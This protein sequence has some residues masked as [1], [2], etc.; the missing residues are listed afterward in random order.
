MRMP[1]FSEIIVFCASIPSSGVLDCPKTSADR[2][3]AAREVVERL[4]Q[5]GLGGIISLMSQEVERYRAAEKEA[6]PSWCT[7][8]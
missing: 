4:R 1:G 7:P 3:Y 5:A 2:R 6:R 8:L